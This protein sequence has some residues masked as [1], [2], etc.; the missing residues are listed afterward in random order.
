MF[1]C[2]AGGRRGEVGGDAGILRLDQGLVLDL[3]VAK[4]LL[5]VL[6]GVVEEKAD[7][8]SH[9]CAREVKLGL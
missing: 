5:A 8:E 2:V 7:S 4:S 1:S 6:L 9:C 3:E